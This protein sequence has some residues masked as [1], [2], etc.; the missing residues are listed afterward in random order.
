MSY[1]FYDAA[2]KFIPSSAVAFNSRIAA[3]IGPFND[4]INNFSV[5]YD[6]SHYV[7]PIDHVINDLGPGN[8]LIASDAD[9]ALM[10]SG[11][12]FTIL[13]AAP[14]VTGQAGC[15]FV[16]KLNATSQ[17][18][19]QPI[20]PGLARGGNPGAAPAP[21]GGGSSATSAPP[22]AGIGPGVGGLGNG[23]N[24]TRPTQ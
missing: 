5:G 3:I 2:F 15:S 7:A 18:I 24:P 6:L 4:D 19:A 20:G 9:E 17:A 21:G 14:I 8:I 1:S 23:H 12:G 11:L 13:L 10:E 22:A 16:G